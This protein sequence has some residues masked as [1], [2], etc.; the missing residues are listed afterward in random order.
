MINRI[1]KTF[2][3]LK[4]NKK[5]AFIVYIT[6][7]Y[8]SLSAT[9]KIVLELENSGVDIIE[10]GMPFSDPMADGLTIQKSSE[11]SLLAGTTLSKLLKTAKNIRKK[12]QIPIVLM[13]Y[14]NPVY[15]YGIKK[16]VKDAI[17]CGIDGA[18]FPDLP[19]EEAIEFEKVAK[20]K[21]FYLI[22][23][24]SPTSTLERLKAITKHSKGFIYY[25]SL[26]GI[27]GARKYLAP[28]ISSNIKRIKH[29]TDK[30]VC[31]G[32]GVSNE[33]QAEAISKVADG[34][35]IGSAV[36]DVIRKHEKKKNL[37]IAVGRFTSCLAKAVHK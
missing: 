28:H 5:K 25:V 6:A 15:C 22:F 34:I 10:M 18:I 21:N 16:F 19:P 33:R 3:K 27:T 29:L 31:V 17:E 26:A 23:L 7:G 4:K 30:P 35:I 24:A 1:K 9:E 8:P 32:F 20:G 11:K 36:I 37:E 13:S 14:L 12:S 2:N